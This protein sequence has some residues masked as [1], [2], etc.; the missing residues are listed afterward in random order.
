MSIRKIAQDI[1]TEISKTELGLKTF[2]FVDNYNMLQ[3]QM[4]VRDGSPDSS[5]GET[6]TE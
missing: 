5:N 6:D 2:L 3:G 1:E 4:L